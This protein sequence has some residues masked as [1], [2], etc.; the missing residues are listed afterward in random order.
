MTLTPHTRTSNLDTRPTCDMPGCT[1]KAYADARLPVYGSWA[2]VCVL[3]FEEQGCSL[4]L[5]R[6]Q[7]LDIPTTPKEGTC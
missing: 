6:G 1:N 2:Y 7:E 4:G 5:G 3:H